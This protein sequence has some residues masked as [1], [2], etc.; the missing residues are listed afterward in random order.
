MAAA[1]MFAALGQQQWTTADALRSRGVVAEATVE[2]VDR[3]DSWVRARFV[4]EDGHDVAAD[5]TEWSWDPE[6]QVGDRQTVL[7]DPMDPEHVVVDTRMERDYLWFGV[8]VCLAAAFTW[9]G[10]GTFRGRYRAFYESHG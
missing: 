1:L 5:V 10:V 2:H 6:P 8:F 3:S 4:T 9:F 7:Y